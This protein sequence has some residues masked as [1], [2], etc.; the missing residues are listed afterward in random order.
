[1]SINNYIEAIKLTMFWNKDVTQIMRRHNYAVVPTQNV[2]L[3][4]LKVF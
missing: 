4:E 3:F 1:M 2:T